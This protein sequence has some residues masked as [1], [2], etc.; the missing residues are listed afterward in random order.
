MLHPDRRVHTRV[1]TPAGRFVESLEARK[2]FS[3]A[4]APLPLNG[5]V[6]IRWHGQNMQAAPGQWIAIINRS[7]NGSHKQLAILNEQLTG[8]GLRAVK[9]LDHHSLFLL[10]GNEQPLADVK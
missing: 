5:L 3:T 6:P 8:T 9:R 1:A 10:R 2:L 7:L 4:S